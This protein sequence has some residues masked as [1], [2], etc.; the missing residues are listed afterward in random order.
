MVELTQLIFIKKQ[1]FNWIH[2]TTNRR[3]NVVV[4]SWVWVVGGEKKRG[5]GWGGVGGGG[6]GT[7]SGIFLDWYWGCGRVWRNFWR[8]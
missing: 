2:F 4:F 3:G 8:K 7:V 5:D 6:G 1:R